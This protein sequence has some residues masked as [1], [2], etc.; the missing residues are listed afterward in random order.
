MDMVV[1]PEIITVGFMHGGRG[2]AIKGEL[3]GRIMQRYSLEAE[4]QGQPST[5]GCLHVIRCA[6]CVD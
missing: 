2:A 4:K 1:L 6:G 5:T 3:K